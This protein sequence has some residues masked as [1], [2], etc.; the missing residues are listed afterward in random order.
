MPFLDSLDI[1]NRVC[2]ICG[3]SPIYEVDEDSQRN[4]T[5]AAAY[6]KLR[7]AEL[8]RSIWRF[9]IRKAALRAVDS[10]TLHISPDAWSAS[11]TYALGELVADTNGQVWASE[12]AGN[13]NNS[14]G[15][16]NT[17]WEMHY[18]P[19]TADE[20]EA[21]TAYYSGEF[22]YV[23]TAG[24]P[25][26]Y[27]VYMSLMNGNEDVPGTVSA[28]D[29]D[30]NYNQDQI[31]NH[32]GSQWRSRLPVNIGNTPASG[33]L[34]WAAATAYTIGQQ[35]TGS[36]NYIYTATGSTTGND[37]TTDG[38]SHWTNTDD[39]NAWASVTGYVSSVN[40]RP[41]SCALR[42][43]T[44]N[45]PI[46]TG[47]LSQASTRNVFRLPSGYLRRAPQ[48]EKIPVAPLGG[49]SGINYDDW[50]MNGPYIVSRETGPIILRFVADI[51]K[52]SAMDDMFC[53]GLAYRIATA[54]APELTQSDTKLQSIASAYKLF[55][56]EARLVNGIEE[57][58]QDP[59]DDTYLSVRY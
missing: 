38:G 2:Q 12:T 50:E 32:S 48:N 1:A 33:P 55:Q 16:S 9:A 27:Q 18:G 13:I 17:A 30:T 36:D 47:P 46:G 40:W 52:T 35:V 49:P 3:V 22:V 44:L 19:L 45:W 56:G 41:M 42:N 57:G 5:I 11:K 43:I 54:V 24:A 8:Q 25:S 34:S 29:A 37:P 31:V 26:G 59:P 14:P 58:Y 7:R 28:W 6:D 21:S 15:G 23:V 20:W 39:L 51:V 4:K 53:E 10:N